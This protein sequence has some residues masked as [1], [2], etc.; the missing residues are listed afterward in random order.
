MQFSI[1]VQRTTIHTTTI[2]IE[3]DDEDEAEDL[4]EQASLVQTHVADLL[5]KAEWDL[6][7]E[8]YEVEEIQEA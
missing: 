3:A 4:I 8:N 5:A 1:K 7:D 2:E 6:E